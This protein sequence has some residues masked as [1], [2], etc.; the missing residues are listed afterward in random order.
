ME[1]VTSQLTSL[2][3]ALKS[4]TGPQK[5]HVPTHEAGD[6]RTVSP[7]A[8]V[9]LVKSPSIS[10]DAANVDDHN[11]TPSFYGIEDSMN[12]ALSIGEQTLGTLETY[13]DTLRTRS[14]TQSTIPADTF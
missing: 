4:H 13:A 10:V 7:D 11:D 9:G 8:V 12:S 3:E 14:M 5:L 6:S 1:E 2:Q